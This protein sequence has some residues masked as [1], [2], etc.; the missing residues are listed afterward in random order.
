MS[1]GVSGIRRLLTPPAFDDVEKT[2]RA[3]MLFS[4]G[5]GSA[6]LV[7]FVNALSILVSPALAVRLALLAVV[8]DLAAMGLI[9]AAR[10]GWV[11]QASMAWVS[12]VWVIATLTAWTGGGLNAPAILL[13]LVVVVLAGLLLGWRAN[14][15]AAGAA[16]LVMFG[17]W[18]A[19]VAGVLPV[20]QPRSALFRATTLAGYVA[21]LALLSAAAMRG[22]ERLRM[23][24]RREREER[25][26]QER[27]REKDAT[28]RRAY[29]E[30]IDAVTGGKL[31]LMTLDEIE[32]ALGEPVD[33]EREIRPGELGGA[34]EWLR[35][36]LAREFPALGDSMLLID[37][38][39]EALTNA[40]KHA[41]GGTCRLYRK[42]HSIQF[43][44]TD[45]GPG[46]DFA[47]LPKAT[48][49]AGYSTVG[50]LGR[51]F[52]V[53]LRRCDRVLLSTQPGNTTVV[54][55]VRVP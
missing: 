19:Q 9:A 31:L 35:R 10:R 32:H 34:I 40:V 23:S 48:L 46:I 20:A 36:T 17:M 49:Q 37:P 5:V 47:H 1:E 33:A 54:L 14:L 43:R 15:V 26:V 3:R 8:Y 55:E 18:Y 45:H 29:V 42:N 27:L 51:G 30:V 50:T 38:A 24:L 44:V 7:T 21:V 52:D 6:I 53:M 16:I 41:G 28:I 22:T 2:E 25:E 12:S 13:Q 39:G 4:I 11:D